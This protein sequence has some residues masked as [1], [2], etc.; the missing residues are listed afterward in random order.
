MLAKHHY[1]LEL[2]K[3]GNEVYFLNPPDNLHWNLKKDETRIRISAVPG[4]ANLF[5][6]DQELYFPYMLKYHARKIYNL[7]VKKQIRAILKKIG[8]PV[9]ILWSFDL[10]NLFPMRFFPNKIY[11]IF[12]PVDEPGD[13]YALDAASGAAVIF[14]VTREILDKYATYKIPSHFVNHGLAEEFFPEQPHPYIKGNPVNVGISGNLLRQDL[15]RETLIQIVEEN[16]DLVFNFYGS[17]K[18]GDSNIGAGTDVATLSFVE[19]LQS[20]RQV[21]LHGVLKTTELAAQLNKMD[22]FLICYD[23]NKDQSKGTNYHK[24]MEYLSTGRVIVSNNITTYRDQ[25]IL[26]RMLSDRVSNHLLPQL[27]KDTVVHLEEFNS[28]E[29][30]RQRISYACENSYEKQLEEIQQFIAGMN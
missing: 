7:L 24:V 17:Y 13:Q 23:I 12:H 14:S 4:H 9:D 18:T 2:A 19:R 26:V 28:L 3:A 25:P 27:F 6:I 22:L 1:A 8:H 21:V 11:K 29:N 16:P 20:N 15:D 30:I 10:G 5:V